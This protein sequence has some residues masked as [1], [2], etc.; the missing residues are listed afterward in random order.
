[1]GSSQG[2]GCVS[3]GP[4]RPYRVQGQILYGK[5]TA[6][7]TEG[8]IVRESRRRRDVLVRRR[9]DLN[10][11]IDILTQFLRVFQD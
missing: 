7:E 4:T 1:M 6:A 5:D 2:S 10:S 8:T 9:E 11:Q 3:D